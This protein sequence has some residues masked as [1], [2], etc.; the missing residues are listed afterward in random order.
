MANLKITQVPQGSSV[1]TTDD[2]Y[3]KTGS[4]FRR[5]PVSKLIELMNAQGFFQKGL[6]GIPTTDLYVETVIIS[7]DDDSFVS[8]KTYSQ[9]SA[10]E[11]SGAEIQCEFYPGDGSYLRGMVLDIT[12]SEALLAFLVPGPGPHISIFAVADLTVTETRIPISG[13]P[14]R[15]VCNTE[16]ETTAKVATVQGGASGL[17]SLYDGA[18]VYVYFT[19][20][21][22]PGSTLNINSTGAKLIDFCGSTGIPAES[23][24]Q[25]FYHETLG[26]WILLGGGGGGSGSGLTDDIKTALLNAFANVAWVNDDGQDYYDALNAALNPERMLSSI[27]ASYDQDHSIYDSDSQETAYA[28]IKLDLVVTANY[29]DGTSETLSDSDYTLSGSLTAGTNT[30]TVSYQNKTDTI[31]VLILHKVVGWYYPFNQS[32]LSEGTEE[33]GFV[34]QGVYA[35][36]L[37][38]RKCYSHIVPVIDDTSSDTQL[39]LKATGLTKFPSLGGD[40]T[41]SYWCKTQKADRGHPVW[42]TYYQSGNAP[43]SKYYSSV[44][45]TSDGTS[46]GWSSAGLGSSGL[47]LSGYAHQFYP[48]NSNNGLCLRITNNNK[49]K[50]A[51]IALTA[52]ASFDFT[53]WHHY[54]M[55]RKGTTVRIFIDG[56]HIATATASDDTVYAANQIAISS[57]FEQNAS[58]ASDLAPAGWG[59]YVQDLYIAESCKWE[60]SF[61]PTNIEY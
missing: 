49:T 19:Y 37:F 44:S 41:V 10:A 4:N 48:T 23:F 21:V 51:N 8:S 57:Y 34:G 42:M 50:T 45:I 3:I 47:N 59:E 16:E 27:T 46:A 14:C 29:S 39:G 52:P 43:A 30:F 2:I 31:S 7:P 5:V 32:L 13:Q 28:T 60:A 9:I 33:F 24:A 1:G 36:G 11:E 17:F 61:D 6:N 25:F 38:N 55:T 54:A 58:H 53:Q 18:T 26:K 12:D 35:D 40:Y 22:A 20:A 15:A 56:V